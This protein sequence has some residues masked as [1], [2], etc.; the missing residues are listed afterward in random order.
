MRQR[1][2]ADRISKM[3]NS[4]TKTFKATDFDFLKPNSLN[5]IWKH[6]DKNKKPKGNVYF[7]WV[8]RGLYKIK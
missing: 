6:S 7:T 4:K 2:L 1:N 3:I 5:F 8:S